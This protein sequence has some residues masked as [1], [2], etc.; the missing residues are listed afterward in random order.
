MLTHTKPFSWLKLFS[1]LSFCANIPQHSIPQ[2]DPI[3]CIA[4][5]PT[6]SSILSFIKRICP[7]IVTQAPTAPI[8][9]A[10]HVVVTAHIPL[11]KTVHN[12]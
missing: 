4:E 11:K 12:I 3:K 2:I 6:G 10:A 8:V 5:A 7:N 1:M 9:T